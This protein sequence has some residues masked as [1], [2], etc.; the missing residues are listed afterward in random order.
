MLLRNLKLWKSP[1]ASYSCIC[2]VWCL[3]KMRMVL[4]WLDLGIASWAGQ[5]PRLCLEIDHAMV[6]RWFFWPLTCKRQPRSV[7]TPATSRLHRVIQSIRDQNI[8][9]LQDSRTTSFLETSALL[10]ITIPR[11]YAGIPPVI[12]GARTTNREPTQ[13]CLLS[14]TKYSV[15]WR[16]YEIYW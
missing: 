4:T 16:R 11:G 7:F 8:I 3:L 1:T 13:N 15:A 2:N 14:K 6:A 10:L 12:G 5:I 9:L